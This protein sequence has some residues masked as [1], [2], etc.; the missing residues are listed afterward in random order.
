MAPDG[1]GRTTRFPKVAKLAKIG[2]PLRVKLGLPNARNVYPAGGHLEVAVVSQ[3]VEK[4]RRAQIARV[5]L[6]AA[7]L[8]SQ[9]SLIGSGLAQL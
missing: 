5:W 1:M 2:T 9:N 7:V 6:A 8:R 4:V 3:A